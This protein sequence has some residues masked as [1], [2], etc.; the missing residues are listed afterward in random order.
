MGVHEATHSFERLLC[1]LNSKYSSPLDAY[2][3]CMEAKLIVEE[4]Y[5][6]IKTTDFGKGKTYFDLLSGISIIA[7]ETPSEALSEAFADCYINKN[8]ANPF[9][10]EIKRVAIQRYKKLKGR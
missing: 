7:E 9:S 10:I 1:D 4:A 6:K 3:S 2:K 8:R 5:N